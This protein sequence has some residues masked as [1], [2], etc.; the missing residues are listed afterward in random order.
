MEDPF[1]DCLEEPLLPNHDDH[2]EETFAHRSISDEDVNENRHDNVLPNDSEF[3]SNAV[4]HEI[5]RLYHMTFMPDHEIKMFGQRFVDGPFAVKLLKFLAMTLV[6]VALVHFVVEQYISDRDQKLT[7]E[8]ILVYEGDAII[9]DCI[10]F[11]VVGRLWQKNGVDSCDWIL[12]MVLANVYFECQPFFPWMGHSVTL[13]EMHCLWPWQ[14]WAFVAFVVPLFLTIVVAHL[15]KA[16]RQGLLW[17]KIGEFG[18]C[19]C[20]F[21]GPVLPSPYFHFH[22]WFAGW[23]FGM[24][25]NSDDWWSRATMAY[26]HGMYVNGIAVYGRDPLLTCDYARFM[27]EDQRCPAV[28]GYSAVGSDLNAPFSWWNALRFDLSDDNL[29][30]S[31]WRNCSSRGYHP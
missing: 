1:A 18:I 14:L 3:T 21:L 11:Y 8:D 25:A 17:I 20:L 2:D 26:F 13:Y 12:W 24:H 19:L 29:Q 6:S 31:D 9:R 30:P 23:I 15:I 22:H 16:F 28:S 7:L 5:L 4:T 27:A 10:V